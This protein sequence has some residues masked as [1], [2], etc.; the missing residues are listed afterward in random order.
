MECRPVRPNSGSYS[1]ACLLGR[2][3]QIMTS[4]YLFVVCLVQGPYGW[5][6]V[7]NPSRDTVHVQYFNSRSNVAGGEYLYDEVCHL[8][9]SVLWPAHK[10]LTLF[11]HFGLYCIVLG[12]QTWRVGCGSWMDSSLRTF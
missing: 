4:L 11:C 7:S 12:G 10:L 5:A 6:R 3:D 1:A 8:S 9:F 2:A